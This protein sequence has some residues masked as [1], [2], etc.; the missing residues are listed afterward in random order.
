MT[1][2]NASKRSIV[3]VYISYFVIIDNFTSSIFWA[4]KGF[5]AKIVFVLIT[6]NGRVELK[7]NIKRVPSFLQLVFILEYN[8]LVTICH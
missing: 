7:V 8:S 1:P 2:T 6:L 3:F 4:K 5:Y